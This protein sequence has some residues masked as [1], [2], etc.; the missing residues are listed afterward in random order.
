MTTAHTYFLSLIAQD[1]TINLRIP[2]LSQVIVGRG[3]PRGAQRVDLDL[4]R[5]GADKA[6]VSRR[7]LTLLPGDLL[8]VR[9]MGSLNGTYLNGVSLKP[10]KVYSLVRGD[11]LRIGMMRL[12]VRAAAL[13]TPARAD[14]EIDPGARLHELAAIIP[15]LPLPL[16]DN[17]LPDGQTQETPVSA[18]VR[19]TDPTTLDGLLK[20]LEQTGKSDLEIAQ[21]LLRG[22]IAN[23]PI[24]GGIFQLIARQA[25]SD[26]AWKADQRQAVLNVA[27]R[28]GYGH[29]DTQR[30][31][32]RASSSTAP[33]A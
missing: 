31:A 19:R 6:G 4:T 18:D 29:R 9:D 28:F 26:K 25:T 5:Y 2:N 3:D 23:R 16:L 33:R 8:Q 20:R 14:T 17:E 24:T 10:N 15:M 1:R 11:E 27:S 32:G 7:H 22:L 21:I 13:D 30:D 12:Q